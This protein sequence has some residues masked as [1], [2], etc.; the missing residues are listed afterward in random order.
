MASYAY[1][2]VIVIC[3][4][5]LFIAGPVCKDNL[6]STVKTQWVLHQSYCYGTQIHTFL[7]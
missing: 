3:T 5:D 2:N 1:K 6:M 7:L 4:H